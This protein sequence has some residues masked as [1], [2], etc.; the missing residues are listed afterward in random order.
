[1]IWRD[2]KFSILLTIVIALCAVIA[3]VGILRYREA[4]PP[5]PR[6]I[7]F[8]AQRSIIGGLKILRPGSYLMAIEFD[9]QLPLREKLCASPASPAPPAGP[10]PIP[11]NVLDIRWR[12]TQGERVIAEGVVMRSGATLQSAAYQ[13]VTLGVAELPRT[14]TLTF[15]IWLGRDLAW[16]NAGNPRLRI[17]ALPMPGTNTRG[18]E[19]SGLPLT[20]NLFVA[21]L[22]FGFILTMVF[23]LEWALYKKRSRTAIST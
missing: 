22:F 21:S 7:D 14:D 9:S 3:G 19:D 1:M 18:N 5:D 16:M 15:S 2:F 8:Q 20:I 4:R 17:S 11:A 10:C 23:P 13:L 6:P 12:V